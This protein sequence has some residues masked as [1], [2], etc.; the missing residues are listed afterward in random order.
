ML[1]NC[2]IARPKCK[3]ENREFLR[4][5]HKITLTCFIPQAWLLGNAIFFVFECCLAFFNNFMIIGKWNHHSFI[6]ECWQI[7][8]C[9]KN[10]SQNDKHPS[11]DL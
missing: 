8:K 10:R 3:L 4:K 7:C 2:N 9:Q 5:T 1:I 11:Y 6:I